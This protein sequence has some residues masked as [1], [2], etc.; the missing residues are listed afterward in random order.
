[1]AKPGTVM[2]EDELQALADVRKACVQ[3]RSLICVQESSDYSATLKPKTYYPRPVATAT[4][5]PARP[6]GRSLPPVPAAL[7]PPPA[8]PPCGFGRGDTLVLLQELRAERMSHFKL[9]RLST[10]SPPQE[11]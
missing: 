10:P 5:D 3:L 8:L 11:D 9:L 2:G 4:N 7:P 6:P 1:M